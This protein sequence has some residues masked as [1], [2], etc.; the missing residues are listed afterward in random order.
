MLFTRITY[1]IIFILALMYAAIMDGVLRW[2]YHFL[3]WQFVPWD[4]VKNVLEWISPWCWWADSSTFG[5]YHIQRVSLALTVWHLILTVLTIPTVMN[6]ETP[7]FK[8]IHRA[9]WAWLIKIPLLIA[10][11]LLTLLI[12]TPVF[13]A[14]MIFCLLLSMAFIVCQ[15]ILLTEFSIRISNAMYAKS[16]D[17]GTPVWMIVTIVAAVILIVITALQYIITG[18]MLIFCVP[19]WPYL[20]IGLIVVLIVLIATVA[21]PRGVL[22]VG[23]V[24][25]LFFTYLM[26]MVAKAN[27]NFWSSYIN[28]WLSFITDKVDMSLCPLDPYPL[29]KDWRFIRW[30]P[31]NAVVSTL[32][33]YLH[34]VWG[35]IFLMAS[36]FIACVSNISFAPLFAGSELSVDEMDGYDSGEDDDPASGADVSYEYWRFHLIVALAAATI[37]IALGSLAAGAYAWYMPLPIII[38]VVVSVFLYV[39]ALVAPMILK[40]RNFPG[41][42]ATF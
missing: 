16:Q 8:K 3:C 33:G 21:V 36:V 40:D 4:S 29:I 26:I 25:S 32:F 31:I 27:S 41:M 6:V 24:L 37:P 34:S 11:Y 14:T 23:A 13:Y 7:I 22:L 39:W 17:D 30:L 19:A 28:G 35:V 5:Y 38:A 20:V 9:G 12:P 18:T 42:K 15:T 1:F 10:L 2:A